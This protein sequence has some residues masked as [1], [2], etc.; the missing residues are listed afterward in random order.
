MLRMFSLVLAE[1]ALQRIPPEIASVPAIERMA[2]VAKR[3]ATKMILDASI[4]S[5]AMKHLQDYQ[6]KGRPDI[7]HFCSL[8]ALDSPL[9]SEGK[10]RFFM[11]TQEGLVIR[12]HPSVRLPRVYPRFLGVMQDVLDGRTVSADGVTLVEARQQSLASLLSEINSP[13]TLV[14]DPSG[15]ASTLSSFSSILS[16]DSYPHTTLVVGGFP[17][18]GFTDPVVQSLPRYS[19]SSKTLSAWTVVADVLSCMRMAVQK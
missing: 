8:L 18:G 11:H 19:L 9:S 2:S 6:R 14:L 4:H 1:T 10:L 13:R 7:A 3:P 15:D 12:F 5:F 17:H 16:D